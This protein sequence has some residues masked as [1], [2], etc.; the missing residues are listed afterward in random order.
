MAVN[1]SSSDYLKIVERFNQASADVL[2]YM[3]KFPSAS[4]S[5]MGQID[6]LSNEAHSIAEVQ[7]D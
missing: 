4:G 5:L 7:N 3:Q 6:S 1:N 2:D